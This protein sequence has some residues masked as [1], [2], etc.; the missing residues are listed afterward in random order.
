MPWM[1]PR[2]NL[3]NHQSLWL[4][5]VARLKPGVSD[6]QAEA[7]LGPLWH[8]LREQELTLLQIDNRALQESTSSTIRGSRF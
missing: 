3:N 8:S 5:L 7:G 1:V 4:T 2:D 6:T